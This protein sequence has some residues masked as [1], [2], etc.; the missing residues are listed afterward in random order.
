MLKKLEKHGKFQV[1]TDK[2]C[3]KTLQYHLT[4]ALKEDWGRTDSERANLRSDKS[5]LLIPLRDAID[6][7][8]KINGSI[9]DYVEIYES[10]TNYLMKFEEKIGYRSDLPEDERN[11]V[12]KQGY[13]LYIRFKSNFIEDIDDIV[14][15]VFTPERVYRFAKGMFPIGAGGEGDEEYRIE[16]ATILLEASANYLIGRIKE[17]YRDLLESDM[18]KAIQIAHIIAKEKGISVYQEG[19]GF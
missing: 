4:K 6:A 7:I 9:G 5:R 18:R 16:I 10:K 13:S 1:E 3:N 14:Q 12:W 8:L 19:M 11:S 17:N 15:D 2:F